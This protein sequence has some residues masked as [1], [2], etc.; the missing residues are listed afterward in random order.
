[1]ATTKR[2]RRESFGAVRK[3]PSG[4]YQASYVGVDGA[5][6][7]A[8]KT[9][10]TM[11]DARG[12]LAAQ[13]V[14]LHGGNWQPPAVAARRTE[15]F[16]VYATD[17]IDRRR[18]K[19]QPL[20]PRTREE[21]ARLLAGPLASLA[22][23][24]MDKITREQVDHWHSEQS[25]I[26]KLTQTSRGYALIKAVMADAL[27]R[28]IITATPARVRGGASPNTGRKVTPPTD[29]ELEALHAAMVPLYRALV[30]VA[31]SGGLRYGEMTE[32]R[33]KDITQRQN[34]AA[35]IRVERAVVFLKAGPL[36]GPPKS[37]AGVRSVTLPKDGSAELLAHMKE[38]VA[39]DPEA[40]IF[41]A[42]DG[43]HMPL[44]KF[45]PH[46][47]R[48]RLEAGRPDLGIHALRHYALTQFASTPG[49]T[50]AAIMGRAGHSTV[51]TAMN[52]QHAAADLDAELAARM[53]GQ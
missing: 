29:A 4:R 19:G 49:A 30:T 14:K 41:P 9:Y 2:K 44:W 1:M 46:W 52:Y 22:E 23:T 47:R 36:V 15:S 31:G 17:W 16:A 48:A 53:G 11:T 7:T 6:Y 40:L 20:R 27:D 33:R 45:A 37:H 21:Y 39:D 8:P 18:V 35:T 12:W 34:G 32:L 42:L 3:L 43:T 26:G 13:S 50:L 24:P 51:T 38:Y 10:D 28:G 5:R 25:A